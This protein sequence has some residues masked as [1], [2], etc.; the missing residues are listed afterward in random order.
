VRFE[1]DDGRTKVTAS[2]LSR[3]DR[4]SIHFGIVLDDDAA[5]FALR[6]EAGE[7]L[8]KALASL[9]RERRQ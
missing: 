2:R 9:S 7:L 8:I 5:T 4:D 6:P 1:S 3:K